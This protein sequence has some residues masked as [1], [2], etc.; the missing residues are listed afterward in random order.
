MAFQNSA[1][2]GPGDTPKAF[3]GITASESRTETLQLETLQTHIL[4]HKPSVIEQ[5]GLE[6]T[7]AEVKPPILR[8]TVVL[9]GAGPSTITKKLNTTATVT[10]TMR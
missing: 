7:S 4:T 5:I 1:F 2:Q 9:P 6:A 10:L 3:Q 8:A